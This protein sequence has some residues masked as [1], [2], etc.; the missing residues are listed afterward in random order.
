MDGSGPGRRL[1]LTEREVDVV[2]VVSRE[3]GTGSNALGHP[4]LYVA[5][6]HFR[7]RQRRRLA[8]GAQPADDHD[9]AFGYALRVS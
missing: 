4:Y 8:R 3:P 9:R 2:L 6:L 7:L 5:D 1:Q